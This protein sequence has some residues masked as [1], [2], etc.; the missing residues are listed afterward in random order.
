MLQSDVKDEDWR[1][2]LMLKCKSSF[3]YLSAVKKNIYEHWQT[4]HRY[5]TIEAREDSERWWSRADYPRADHSSTDHP[6]AEESKAECSLSHEWISSTNQK[7]S[8]D[9]ALSTDLQ[10]FEDRHKTFIEL[11]WK[12]LIGKFLTNNHSVETIVFQSRD[13]NPMRYYHVSISN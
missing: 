12:H 8:N 4:V 7:A 5:T 13:L 10:S 3:D 1:Y 2:S 9:Y 11:T 6:R